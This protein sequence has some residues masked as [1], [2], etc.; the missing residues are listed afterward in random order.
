MCSSRGQRCIKIQVRTIALRHNRANQRGGACWITA[1]RPA[2]RRGSVFD[3]PDRE[4]RART[5]DSVSHDSS[6]F[7]AA[8]PDRVWQAFTDGDLTAWYFF[9]SRVQS[10]WRPGDQIVYI[11]PDGTT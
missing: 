4:G 1:R 8:T 2:V 11:G 10:G 7:G 9:G 5:G 6:G 3:Q